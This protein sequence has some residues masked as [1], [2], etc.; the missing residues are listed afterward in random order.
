MYGLNLH[1]TINAVKLSPFTSLFSFSNSIS[2]DR[3]S[4]LTS[5]T[6]DDYS[7]NLSAVIPAKSYFP[8]YSRTI[9]SAQSYSSNYGFSRHRC[10]KQFV[11]ASHSK[12]FSSSNIAM[13]LS[14]EKSNPANYFE[15]KNKAR[16]QKPPGAFAFPCALSK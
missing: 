16:E 2:N 1:K 3:L 7:K 15:D 13:N 5:D 8:E 4:K 10:I 12:P 14:F 11:F 9:S 6:R